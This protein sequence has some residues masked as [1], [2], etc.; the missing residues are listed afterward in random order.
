[1]TYDPKLFADYNSGIAR[2]RLAYSNHLDKLP[3]PLPIFEVTDKKLCRKR[4]H[5]MEAPNVGKDGRCRGCKAEK[6]KGYRK[7]R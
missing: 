1:M 4:L 7:N 3:G 2:S 6:E 5:V